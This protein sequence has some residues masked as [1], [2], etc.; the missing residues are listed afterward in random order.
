MDIT[1]ILDVIKDPDLKIKISNLVSE[2]LQLK[3]ENF[4]LRRKIE[5]NHSERNI[6]SELSFENNHYYINDG[7]KKDGPF[8]TNCWDDEKKLV[9]LHQGNVNN[10]LTYFNCPNCETT[11]SIGHYIDPSPRNRNLY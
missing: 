9:R 5:K 11:T 4:E 8:C 6:Q 7:G 10:G 3:E 1:K 2:N